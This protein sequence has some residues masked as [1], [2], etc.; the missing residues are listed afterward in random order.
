[1]ELATILVVDLPTFHGLCMIYIASRIF[2]LTANNFGV[3]GAQS[4]QSQIYSIQL[5]RL[6]RNC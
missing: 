3:G 4:R 1:M 6:R 5:Y 2:E